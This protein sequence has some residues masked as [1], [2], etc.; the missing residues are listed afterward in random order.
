MPGRQTHRHAG[1]T[2]AGWRPAAAR[3]RPTRG[4]R[5]RPPCRAPLRCSGPAACRSVRAGRRISPRSC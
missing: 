4:P 2:P 5:W 3:A 1:R